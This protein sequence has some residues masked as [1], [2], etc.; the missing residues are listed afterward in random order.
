MYLQDD[1]NRL[2]S[3]KVANLLHNKLLLCL[4][5]GPVDS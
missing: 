2:Q 3:V 4:P 1:N 5:R